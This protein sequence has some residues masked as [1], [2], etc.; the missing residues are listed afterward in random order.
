MNN[1]Q[2]RAQKAQEAE[3]ADY[4]KQER[5]YV[6][7][8]RAYAAYERAQKAQEAK[9]A[10]YVKQEREYVAQD[11]LNFKKWQQQMHAKTAC[12]KSTCY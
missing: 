5:E 4:V 12:K 6:A 11:A 10:D 8:E 2:K 9:I 3:I 7:Q 1:A